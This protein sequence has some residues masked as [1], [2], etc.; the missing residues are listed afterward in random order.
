[1]IQALRRHYMKQELAPTTLTIEAQIRQHQAYFAQQEAAYQARLK[2][3]RQYYSPLA[4][5]LRVLTGAQG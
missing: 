1:M 3:E 5:I 2:A 4:K